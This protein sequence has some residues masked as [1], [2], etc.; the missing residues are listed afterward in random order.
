[1]NLNNDNNIV[2]Y[3]NH[4]LNT[5]FI[6]GC[7]TWATTKGDIAKLYTTERKVLRKIFDP[8]IWKIKYYTLS[9]S[10]NKRIEWAGHVWRAE[11]KIIKQVTE[12][13]I[14]NKRPVV[15]PRIKW[16][17]VIGN[18]LKMIHENVKMEDA[19]DRIMVAAMDHRPIWT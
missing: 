10:R 6:Y 5:L 2:M 13:R 15:R 16:K 3:I 14:V 17:D 1:M 18:D 12:G 19:N 9:F 7:E 4:F 8:F 11:G